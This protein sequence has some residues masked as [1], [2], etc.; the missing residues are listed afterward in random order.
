MNYDLKGKSPAIPVGSLVLV[1]GISGFIGSHVADQLL[2]AG[3]RVR[4]TTRSDDKGAWVRDL[5]TKKYGEGKVETVVVSDMAQEGAFDEAIKAHVASDTSFSPDPNKVIPVAIAGAVNA[6]SAAARQPSVKR[7]VHTSS[8]TAVTSPHLDHEVTI[9]TDQ[10]ND[11]EVEIAWAPPPYNPD[12]SFSV[13]SASKTQAEQ[14]MW[15]FVK[16]QKPGFVLN[17]VLP[18]FNFG[19][20]LSDKQAGSSAAA[21]KRI[22]ETG[23]MEFTH[24]ILPQWMV[25][26]Q[27]TARLH[28]AAL[29]DPDV[30]NQRILAFAHPFNFN[31]ILRILRKLYPS[32]EFP[33]DIE[34]L[35]H[36]LSKIDNR[37]GVELLKK[38]GRP[39]WVSLEE[40]VK[41]NVGL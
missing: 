27:D 18:N 5:F 4:G 9:S 22:Y 15:K 7:F 14:E 25:D 24:R 37:P 26:V 31:D 38:F 20:V 29:I 41:D 17:C 1:T 30:E 23:D 32:K 39:G 28:V 16:E 10:W 34:G 36:D 40:T 21:I 19:T 35:G 8:S 3:Y 2:Q 11:E 6:A 12:R 13:Y 33:G